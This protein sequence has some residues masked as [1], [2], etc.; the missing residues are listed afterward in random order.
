MVNIIRILNMYA[1]GVGRLWKSTFKN[2]NL[3]LGL[4]CCATKFWINLRLIKITL[5][6]R[7]LKA[8]TLHRVISFLLFVKSWVNWMSHYLYSFTTIASFYYTSILVLFFWMW[9]W[10][11]RKI[12]MSV[13]K[14]ITIVFGKFVFINLSKLLLEFILH[15]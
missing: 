2:K 5:A 8:Y 14:F 3:M 1:C 6:Y 10:N 13:E 15:V 9:L 11:F 4:F 12:Y 7:C